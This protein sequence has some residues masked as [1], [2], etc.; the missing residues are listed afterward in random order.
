M[1]VSP[2]EAGSRPLTGVRPD[3]RG[4]ALK[5]GFASL[6]RW[7]GVLA[8]LAYVSGPSYA[9][10][11]CTLIATLYLVHAA[12]TRDLG[13]LRQDWLLVG[14]ALWAY[15]C[16]RSLFGEAGQKGFVLALTFVRFPI[17]AV[18]MQRL[19]L[20]ET[21]WRRRLATTAL[22]A[23]G[24]LALDALIQYATGRDVL[25][26]PMRGFRLTAFYRHF[27][28]G[29]MLSWLFVPVT[30]HFVDRKRYA[31]AAAFGVCCFAAIV[32]SGDRMALLGTLLALVLAGLVFRKARKTF[33]IALPLAL[34]LLA[35][36]LA[37]S[38]SVYH[39]QVAS[40]VETIRGFEKSHY[41]TIWRSTLRIW[42]DAPLFGVGRGGYRAVC[43]DPKYGPLYPDGP[44]MPRCATHTHNI[45]L[46]WLVESGLVGLGMFLVM[47]AAILRAFVRGFGLGAADWAYGGL[48]VTFIARI[49]PIASWTSFHHAWSAVPFWL[50]IGW[51]LSYLPKTAGRSP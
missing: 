5:S 11:V 12:W 21:I 50:V 49:W 32:L 18:A 42:S 26:H 14:L 8:P 16:I 34:A 47:L 33:L 28:V 27:W 46:E 36:V 25:G 39:R 15:L 4:A 40:T 9:D 44:S 43:A 35:L 13:W 51:G 10:I 2:S 37:V 3:L 19:V 41:A 30:F 48:F 22:V 31:L 24:A 7:L 1:S 38:P 20:D 17:F 6:I 29:A 23:L 45:Y